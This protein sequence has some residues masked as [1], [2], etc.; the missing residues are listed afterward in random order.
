M[1]ENVYI[2][3][4]S[5]KDEAS[6]LLKEATA[7]KKSR[8]IEEAIKILKDAYLKMENKIGDNISVDIL[9][10]LPQYLQEAGKND[11][12]WGEFN[13]LLIKISSRKQ[14]AWF[15]PIELAQIHDKMRLFLQRE[16]KYKI[17]IKHGIFFCLYLAI[18]F[19]KQNRKDQIDFYFAKENIIKLLKKADKE[20]S[21]D[22]I[23]L[24]VEE[25]RK[26]LPNIKFGEVGRQIDMLINE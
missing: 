15:R 13:K 22:K 6:E 26:C 9:A 11:E 8:N 14:H 3:N 18:G 2:N 17:A 21:L 25:Q 5:I 10:R 16:G 19:Y 23:A 12:A 7:M 4:E 20:H 1:A 24:L